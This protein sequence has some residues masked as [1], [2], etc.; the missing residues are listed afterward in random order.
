MEIEELINL[1]KGTPLLDVVG[2]VNP[3]KYI[4][5]SIYS[6][7]DGLYFYLTKFNAGIFEA[8][9]DASFLSGIFCASD[10]SAIKRVVAM[11]TEEDR[12]VL[13]I[14]PSAF[15]PDGAE[16]EYGEILAGLKKMNPKV[17]QESASYRIA[18]D[19]NFVHRTIETEK[20]TFY[21]RGASDDNH[22]APYA[23]LHKY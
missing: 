5:K 11:N 9:S 16:P 13:L 7:G 23:I 4:G 6:L 20:Y 18:T 15:L 8:D 10:D 17:C 12:G 22:E 2:V 19:G 21:F 1:K 14:P 3:E